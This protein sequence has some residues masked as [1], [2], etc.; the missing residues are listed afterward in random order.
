MVVASDV[1]LGRTA[2][3]FKRRQMRDLQGELL[4]SDQTWVLVV[5]NS[6]RRASSADLEALPISTHAEHHEDQKNVGVIVH[7]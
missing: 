5:Y 6:T 2:S 4:R 7:A 1:L 3:G